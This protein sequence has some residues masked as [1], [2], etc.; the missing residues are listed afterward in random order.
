M[1]STT[2]PVSRGRRAPAVATLFALT[3]GLFAY[4]TLE[5]M[6]SPALPM[7][8]KAIGASTPAIAWVFTGLLLAGA[9]ST[10]VIGRLA[11]VRDKRPV[12]LGVLVVVAPRTSP[13]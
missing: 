1:T 5:T 6:L 3:A 13:C 4:S 9:V 10:P 11:D 12:L 8:Q 2:T 7:I